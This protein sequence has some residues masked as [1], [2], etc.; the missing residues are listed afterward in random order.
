MKSIALDII[1][2]QSVIINSHFCNSYEITLSL[3]YSV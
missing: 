2:L 3:I 1:S